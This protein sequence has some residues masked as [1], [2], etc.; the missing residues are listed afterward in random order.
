MTDRLFLDA[1]VLFTAAHRPHGKAAFLF[2][3]AAR[4]PNPP[5]QMFSSAYAAEEARRNLQAKFPAALSDWPAIVARLR[6]VPQPGMPRLPLA[7]PEKDQP[8]WAAC[9]AARCTHLLT[10]DLKDFGPHMNQPE[11]TGG[12]VIQTVG[13]YL[14][15]FLHRMKNPAP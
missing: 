12:I 9:H 13:E 6:V 8:I 4:G 15:A 1:N 3:I 14:A 10:G 2:T 11:Q 5:W 7:L